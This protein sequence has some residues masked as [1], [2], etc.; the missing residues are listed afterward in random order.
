MAK[1]IGFSELHEPNVIELAFAHEDRKSD[2]ESWA[3]ERGFKDSNMVGPSINDD[4]FKRLASK[5]DKEQRQLPLDSL[6]VLIIESRSL[7]FF[8]RDP[9]SI[10][11]ALEEH[12]YRF[13]HLVICYIFTHYMGGEKSDYLIRGQHL[14]IKRPITDLLTEEGIILVNRFIEDKNVT[15]KCLSDIIRGLMQA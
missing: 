4:E 11:E 2:L 6:N 14:Y 3:K 13:G 1:K 15:P 12:I 9:S 10:I 7:V 5:I 8:L